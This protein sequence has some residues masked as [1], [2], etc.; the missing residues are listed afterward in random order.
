MSFIPLHPISNNIE[1]SAYLFVEG[2]FDKVVLDCLFEGDPVIVEFLG[3]C[4]SV[5]SVAQAFAQSP[6]SFFLI[7]R[8]HF[9]K[10]K[11][12]DWNRFQAGETNLLIW[13]KKELEN[14]FIDS[15]FLIRT[16]FLR[17]GVTL[18]QLRSQILKLSQKRLYL[19]V[20]NYIIVS[21]RESM[22]KNWIK[23]LTNP[24]DC[25]DEKTALT[26]I[27][28]NPALS[29]I[30]QRAEQI[31]LESEIKSRFYFYLNEMAGNSKTLL[32]GVGK[33]LD[34]VSGKNILEELLNNS[35][36]FPNSHNGKQWV[37]QERMIDIARR[38][39]SET[40]EDHLPPDFKKLK[41][42]VLQRTK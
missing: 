19:D 12:L 28:N 6:N 13:P 41:H 37:G 16:K 3:S 9:H 25:P 18:E 36:F 7:D 1:N 27:L 10:E 34:M 21:M 20:T 40:F 8:D 17:E 33:W 24:D 38:L 4:N 39:I 11:D 32:N 42:I 14:Y 35:G 5:E 30:K 31:T 22:K 29:T 26:C 23:I 2:I 15:D